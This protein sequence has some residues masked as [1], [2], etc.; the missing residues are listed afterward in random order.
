[1]GL[2]SKPNQILFGE[3]KW[4]N[5]LVGTDILENLVAKSK[6]VA[7]GAEDREEHFALFSKSG[8]TP[9]LKKAAKQMDNVYLFHRGRLLAK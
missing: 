5:K 3:C 1:M 2:G 6:K 7:W 8:F 9:N 4:S